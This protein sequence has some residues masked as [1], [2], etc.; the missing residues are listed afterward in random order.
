MKRDQFLFGVAT[1][2]TQIEGGAFA[3]GKGKSCW[4]YYS[5]HNRIKNGN[6]CYV[7]CDSYNRVEDDIELIRQLGVDSY[8]F[9]INWTRI[10]PLGYGAVNAKGIDYYNRLIDGLLKIGV[11][12]LVTL[13]H[14]DM[15]MPLFE[16][17]SF[18][19]RSIVER[20]AE[21][22]KIV[23]ENFGDRVEMFSVFNEAM[24]LI[25][26]L[27]VRPV[28]GVG[29]SLDDGQVA[30]CIHNLMLSNAAAT[31]ALRR[32]S[33][34]PVKVGMVNCTHTKV[35]ATEADAECAR[36]ATFAVGNNILTN[37]VTFWD[38]LIFG[39]YNDEWVKKFGIDMSFVKDGDMEYIACKPDFL[40][41]NIYLGESVR[42]D[43]NGEPVPATP[44]LN[45]V[46]GEMGGDL[47]GTAAAA[48]WGPKF[49]YERYKLPVYVTEN[50]V[51]LCEWRRAD[52][53]IPD[54]YRC[55]YIKLYTDWLMKAK[56]E[57]IPV[58]GYYVW[59]L[60]DNFEW[61]SGFSRR[62]GLVYVDFE[63]QER[64]PKTSFGYY[65][66]LIS[67]YKAKWRG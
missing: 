46:Y 13:F 58:C 59:T 37:T 50:G 15:P 55:E 34:L 41:L 64:I 40:G 56:D 7:C 44:S 18:R 3:D 5:E 32:Y 23:G 35:P 2:A 11:K 28:G 51:S 67:A 12:P 61:S 57:G 45:A 25:D 19:D 52:G 16:K 62:F 31:Y 8:R 20:F 22:G 9:S 24:A 26:F 66:D 6:T 4:D 39:K 29:E 17:G 53:T 47:V 1:A 10:Q 27:H 30:E 60:M 63:T 36:K 49:L 42:A 65:R 21:Y 38:P 33:K 48:Y 43:E 54:P 14:W